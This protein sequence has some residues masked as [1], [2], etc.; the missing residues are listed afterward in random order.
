[1][2]VIHTAVITC[3]VF[4][5]ATC[6]ACSKQSPV[7]AE[8]TAGPVLTVDDYLK[9]PDVRKKVFASCA[10]DPGRTG[11]DPNCVN[12]LQAERI[13]SAGTGRFPRVTP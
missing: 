9:Q 6:T 5:A 4:V 7:V 2:N 11:D 1:M 10:N 13:A 3:A 12:A 8:A